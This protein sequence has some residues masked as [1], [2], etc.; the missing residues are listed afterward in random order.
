[1]TTA[2]LTSKGRVTI[3][4]SIRELLGLDTGD[5]LEFRLNDRGKVE[6]DPVRENPF[7]RLQG[8]LRDLVGDRPPVTV[9]E[10]HG[11]I[12]Q[13]MAEKFGRR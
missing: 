11:A 1:M 9:E 5:Q 6:I 12:A 3:P 8:M 2:T 13:R 10:M 4:K 7:G